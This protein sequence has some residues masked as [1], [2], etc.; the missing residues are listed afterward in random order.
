MPDNDQLTKE[1]V[2]SM[3]VPAFDNPAFTEPPPLQEARVAIV[4]SAAFF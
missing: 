4:T 2:M 1:R 3:P